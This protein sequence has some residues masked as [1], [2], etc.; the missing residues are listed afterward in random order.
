MG[1]PLYDAYRQPVNCMCILGAPVALGKTCP[2]SIP[3]TPRGA[4]TRGGCQ[5]RGL[6]GGIAAHQTPH[7]LS[8]GCYTNL[9]R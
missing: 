8:H 9:S 2:A 1:P 4:E 6:V 7:W 3:W 5:W